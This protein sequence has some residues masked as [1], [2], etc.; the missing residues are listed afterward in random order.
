MIITPGE[1][2]W[3]ASCLAS[4]AILTDTPFSRQLYYKPEMVY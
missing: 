1:I 3:T 4:S 2:I